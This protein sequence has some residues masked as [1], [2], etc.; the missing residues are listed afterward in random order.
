MHESDLIVPNHAGFI[1]DG[2][3]RWARKRGLDAFEGHLAGQ[4]TLRDVVYRSVDAGVK[5]VSAYAFSTENWSRTEKEVGYLMGQVAKALKKYADELIE[6]DIRV[7]VLGSRDR[8]PKKVIESIEIIENKTAHG[9]RATFAV[10]LNYG[11]HVEI[12]D[13]VKSIVHQGVKP[14]DIT[15]DLIAQN[16]YVPDV[17]PI[18]LI[19]RT[20][21]EQR[22][23][24]FM[25][26]RA[27][28]SEFIFRDEM[29][30]DFT[31]D[32][33]DECLLEYSKRQRRFGG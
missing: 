23:S 5:Y 18:D 26:W 22:L 9:S 25:L 14:D 30:P 11:G 6:N 13:A 29:W 15:A 12:V 27:A 10:C 1:M 7:L 21:G 31:V 17:P 28:Y 24:N 3:R 33:L 16:L 8:L 20:S 32:A 2:N 4:K 19:I